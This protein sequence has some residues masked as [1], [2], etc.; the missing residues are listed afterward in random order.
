MKFKIIPMHYTLIAKA[1]FPKQSLNV[2]NMSGGIQQQIQVRLLFLVMREFK[3]K[4]NSH[5]GTEELPKDTS[6]N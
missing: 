4:I 5:M 6:K 2:N 1:C 3:L